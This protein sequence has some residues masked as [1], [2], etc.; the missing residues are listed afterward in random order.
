MGHTSYKADRARLNQRL[1]S[2]TS[3]PAT[4]AKCGREQLGGQEREVANLLLL[5]EQKGG[6]QPN[7]IWVLLNC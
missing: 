4:G 6:L 5:L 2:G 7:Q 3:S 1:G